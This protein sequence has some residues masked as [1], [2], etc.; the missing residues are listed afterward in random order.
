MPSGLWVQ[1][2]PSALDNML[3]NKGETLAYVIG[4]AIGDGNLSNPNGRA[5]RLRITCD[6]RYPKLRTRIIKAVQKIMPDNKVSLIIRKQ[7]CCDVSCYSNKWEK[8]LGWKAKNGPK[9]KQNIRIPRWIIENKKFSAECL[10]GL[11]ETDGSIYSDRGYKMINFVTIMPRLAKDVMQIIKN[12]N[13]KS[14]LYKIK[15]SSADKYTV[16]ISKN[17]KE[18]IKKISLKKA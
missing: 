1:V 10:R 2:P 13:F 18:F 3:P 17:T 7:N 12:I 4:L 5:I 15:T 14:N 16:R 6:N 8:L 9:H 11:I